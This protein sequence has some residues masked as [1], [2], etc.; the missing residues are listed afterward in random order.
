MFTCTSTSNII[1]KRN[2]LYIVMHALPR[3]WNENTSRIHE[4]LSTRVFAPSLEFWHEGICS[5]SGVLARGY[6]LL[7]WILGTRVFHACLDTL[8]YLLAVWRLGMRVFAACLDAQT[9]TL[10]TILLE[11]LL[12][13]IVRL[14]CIQMKT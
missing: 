8:H 4:L 3:R 10:Y 9:H 2:L 5:L 12:C 14:I 11:F 6:L 13:I 7:V 1:T